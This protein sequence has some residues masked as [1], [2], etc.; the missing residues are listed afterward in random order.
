MFFATVR[1]WSRAA[2][3]LWVGAARAAAQSVIGVP[4]VFGAA[5]PAVGTL[6][7]AG[8]VIGVP[9]FGQPGGLFGVPG[10]GSAIALPSGTC[11]RIPTGPWLAS[12]G[13]PEGCWIAL[14]FKL[15]G[16][17][18]TQIAAARNSDY[19]NGVYIDFNYN[20]A[21]W[22]GGGFRSR[23]TAPAPGT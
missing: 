20:R 19:S 12:I 9:A 7:G 4:Y 14:K 8:T 3:R 1:G 13:T 23:R 16:A 21:P 2:G 18:V 22:P 15:T 17:E 5:D 6:L 11:L 10:G